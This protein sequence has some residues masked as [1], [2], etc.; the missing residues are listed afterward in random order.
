MIK[1][2][3]N[4]SVFAILFLLMMTSISLN[5]RASGQIYSPSLPFNDSQYD[6]TTWQ[7][8][9]KMEDANKTIDLLN[10]DYEL[11]AAA[12]F[13]ATNE[14]RQNKNLPQF[15][16]SRDLRDAADRHSRA[17]CD[18]GFF[19]HNDRKDT[20]NYTPRKRINNVGGRYFIIGE[21]LARVVLHKINNPKNYYP[22]KGENISSQQ[23]FKY[24]DKKEK[25]ELPTET[26]VEFGKKTIKLMI[27][28]KAY[29]TNL[30]SLHF[31]HSA[32]AVALPHEPFKKKSL[33]LGLVTQTFGGYKLN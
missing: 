22:M 24:F 21:N 12:V 19:G 25:E 16:Y 9:Y 4:K 7:E 5:D 27:E 8:F 31:S 17:M 1:G 6:K 20:A 28:N 33:P 10:P 29:L 13:Y 18:S 23:E 14:F 11:L 30:L 3:N 26:Y 15:K 2:I 32:C